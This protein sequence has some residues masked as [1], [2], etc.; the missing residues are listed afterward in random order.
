MLDGLTGV[1]ATT[2][3]KG[4]GASGGAEGELIKGQALTTSLDDAGTGSLGEAEGADGELGDLKETLVISDGANQDE[5]LTLVTLSKP[6][7]ARDGKRRAVDAGLEKT[8]QDK[9]VELSLG[10]AGK[11]AVKLDKQAKVNVLAA[12]SGTATALDVVL[13]DVDTLGRGE[14]RRGE[15]EREGG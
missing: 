9:L 12:R 7:K 1:L 10:T 6:S 8:L 14:E 5:D 11:E 15:E 4:V 13:L 3:K 2:D